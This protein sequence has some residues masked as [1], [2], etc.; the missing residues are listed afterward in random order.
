MSKTIIRTHKQLKSAYKAAILK[1]A[2]QLNGKATTPKSIKGLCRFAE[3]ELSVSI[4]PLVVRRLIEGQAGHGNGHV[5]PPR[6][7]R[8]SV[9]STFRA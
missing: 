6:C 8:R 4:V 3:K 1:K 9:R 5:G 7:N 2:T